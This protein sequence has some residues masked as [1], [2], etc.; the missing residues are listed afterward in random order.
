M[1][2]THLGFGAHTLQCIPQCTRLV[3]DQVSLG[4]P[5]CWCTCSTVHPCCCRSRVPGCTWRT[6]MTCT[7]RCTCSGRIGRRSCSAR[8]SRFSSM[9]ASASAGYVCVR[10]CLCVVV[11]VCACV[12]AINGGCACVCVCVCAFSACVFWRCT[13]AHVCAFRVCASHIFFTRACALVESV[14]QTRTT[15]SERY[16]LKC[17]AMGWG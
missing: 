3:P 14:I 6:V 9:S 10:V 13:C 4:A 5:W 15:E 1:Y 16:G 11:H 2:L 12:R 7:W 17:D 8:P